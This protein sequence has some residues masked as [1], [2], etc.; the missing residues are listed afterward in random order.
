M[1]AVAKK[2]RG[3]AKPGGIPRKNQ[4]QWDTRYTLRCNG[5]KVV[6]D[7]GIPGRVGDARRLARTLGWTSGKGKSANLLGGLLAPQT[8][9]DLCDGCNTEPA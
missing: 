9:W 3:A 2:W 5:C 8:V 6:F 1:T 7:S 4:H